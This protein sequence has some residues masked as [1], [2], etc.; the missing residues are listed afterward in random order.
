MRPST[1]SPFLV[2]S[3]VY[4]LLFLLVY[5]VL[6]SLYL[7][8]AKFIRNLFVS[9]SLLVCRALLVLLRWRSPIH[10][11]NEGLGE[12]TSLT[13]VTGTRTR[14]YIFQDTE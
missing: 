1:Y 7:L 10:A 12:V 5:L 6:F 13:R 4:C 3:S 8:I 9:P 14:V 11:P 2:A